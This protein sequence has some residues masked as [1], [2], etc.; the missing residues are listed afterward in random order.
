MDVTMAKWVNLF[1]CT[2]ITARS[3]ILNKCK[4]W[5]TIYSPMPANSLKKVSAKTSLII[6]EVGDNNPVT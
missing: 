1:F 2:G 5:M 4:S 6:G 3:L